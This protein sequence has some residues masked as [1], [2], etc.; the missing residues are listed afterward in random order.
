MFTF[1]R[2][3]HQIRTDP[4]GPKILSF[5]PSSI[6]EIYRYRNPFSFLF[7]SFFFLLSCNHPNFKDDYLLV[8]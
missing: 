1:S 8:I 6:S 2:E 7:F 4:S 3:V 5:D